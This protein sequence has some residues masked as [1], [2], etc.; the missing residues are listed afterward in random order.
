[1][2]WVFKARY[3]MWDIIDETE[4]RREWLPHMGLT[5]DWHDC[6]CRLRDAVDEYLGLT[7]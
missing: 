1:M 2:A 5:P 3:M 7:M 6:Y 4:Y